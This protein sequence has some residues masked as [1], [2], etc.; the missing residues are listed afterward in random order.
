[1]Q[2][3]DF[4]IL[5]GDAPAVGRILNRRQCDPSRSSRNYLSHLTDDLAIELVS[6]LDIQRNVAWALDELTGGFDL[7][8]ADQLVAKS[9]PGAGGVI[10]LPYLLSQAERIKSVESQACGCFFGMTGETTKA[11]MIRA[12]YESIGYAVWDAVGDRDQIDHI[13][14]GGEA[15]QDSL[16]PRI[17]ANVLDAT[18]SVAGGSEFPSRG[19][20]MACCLATGVYTT[21]E[22]AAQQCARL[23]QVFQPHTKSVYVDG[24]RRYRELRSALA[25]VWKNK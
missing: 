15:E 13:F 1:M 18:V 22:D 2:E 25:P 7:D 14:F 24:F 19:A 23:R 4:G 6:T 3:G 17:I 9:E 12:V 11:Q 16:L 8:L 20:A 10:F 21:P 5:L